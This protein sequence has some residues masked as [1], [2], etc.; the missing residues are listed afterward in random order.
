[1]SGAQTAVPPRLRGGIRPLLAAVSF[2][3]RLP[4]PRRV[5]LGADDVAAAGPAFPLIGAGIGAAVGAL[6]AALA[7][8]LSPLL[9]VAVALAVGSL[10]TGA[11]HLD[12]L[13]DTAD[14]LG[15][16]SRD[17][18]LEI[19]REPTIGAFGAVAVVLDL[20]LKA[21]ALSALVGDHRVV[22]FALVAGALSRLAPVLL[23][24]TL[25]YARPGG[26]TG[27]ALTRSGRLRAVVALAIAAAIAVVWAGRDGAVLLGVSAALV[28]ALG[29]G[30]K[31]WL[32]GVTGDALGTALE[33][34]ETVA[35]IVAVALVG[36]R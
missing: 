24:A 19:M 13:A 9:A 33:L 23:A 29:V 2:L 18:A 12:A 35:L 28:A 6:A 25:T 4:V 7:H 17:R 31:R 5:V 21:A 10:L 15:A 30:F 20:L 11:L 22:R 32:G 3:T 34:S 16:R 14:A 8:P 27:A 26:G 36:G 1:V